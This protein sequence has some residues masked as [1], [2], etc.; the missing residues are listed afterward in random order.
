MANS[1]SNQSIDTIP[2]RMKT[3]DDHLKKFGKSSGTELEKRIQIEKDMF[4]CMLIF[5][6]CTE[7][8]KIALRKLGKD[9]GLSFPLFPL[10]S[11]EE[12]YVTA[13]NS[14]TWLLKL[15]MSTDQSLRFE[16][17]ECIRI[18]RV[19]LPESASFITILFF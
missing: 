2:L 7:H 8:K 6:Y 16:F 18:S 9:K 5:C 11:S 4:D 15:D 3:V 17:P 12:W 1:D 19:Q 10:Q 14:T 13:Y